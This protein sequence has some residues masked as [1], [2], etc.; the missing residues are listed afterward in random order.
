MAARLPTRAAVWAGVAP[1]A[2][3]SSPAGWPRG[4]SDGLTAAHPRPQPAAEPHTVS[5]PV[6]SV[7]AQDMLTIRTRLN[8]CLIWS[9][10]ASDPEIGLT[11][12]GYSGTGLARFS[13]CLI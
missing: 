13:T 7:F 2:D 1:T 10:S 8:T 9:R 11:A 4:A 6:P 5:L 12:G 3:A